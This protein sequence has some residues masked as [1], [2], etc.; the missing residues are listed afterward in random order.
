YGVER[1]YGDLDAMLAEGVVDA[2]TV[3]SPISLHCD[4]CR[5]ALRAGVHVHVNKTMA[6]TVREADELIGLAAA[7]DLRIVASP[8]EVLRPQVTR[9]RELIA[10]GAIGTLAWAICGT[11]FARYHES[12]PER[13]GDVGGTPINPAWYFRK[14]GGGPLYDMTSYALHQLTSVLG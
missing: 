11:A 13:Q 6:T 1:T 12:E 5:S 8:G 3:V 4:H 14:P 9:A 7:G 10:E 2:V